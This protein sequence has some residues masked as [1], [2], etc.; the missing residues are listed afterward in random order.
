MDYYVTVNEDKM[1]EFIAQ[2]VAEYYN[3][4]SVTVTGGVGEQWSGWVPAGDG[5]WDREPGTFKRITGVT[6]T[7]N[8]SASGSKVTITIDYQVQMAILN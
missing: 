7:I 8:A 1:R 2:K 5:N 6:G 4:K 3:G